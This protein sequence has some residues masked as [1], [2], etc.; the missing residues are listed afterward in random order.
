MITSNLAAEQPGDLSPV[1][2]KA[3]ERTVRVKLLTTVALAMLVAVP[4]TIA[5]VATLF[6]AMRQEKKTDEIHVLVNS[7]LT[8]VKA[9]LAIANERIESLTKLIEALQ[10]D[11]ARKDGAAEGKT[12]KK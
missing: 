7:N 8:A 12:E 11:K 1:I 3:E 2:T 4:P 10:E 6:V 9:D 5:A